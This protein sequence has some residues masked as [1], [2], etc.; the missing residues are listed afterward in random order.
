MTTVSYLLFSVYLSFHNSVEVKVEG[1]VS[2]KIRENDRNRKRNNTK[3]LSLTYITGN[4][5]NPLSSLY[6]TF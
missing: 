3:L 2:E 6:K 1:K 5:N 4:Y